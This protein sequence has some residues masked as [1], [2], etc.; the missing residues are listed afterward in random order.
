V[1]LPYIGSLIGVP[2]PGAKEYHSSIAVMSAMVV[3]TAA[4]IAYGLRFR[5]DQV[6][7][8]DPGKCSYVKGSAGESVSNL[9]RFRRAVSISD[10]N[11]SPVRNFHKA[12]INCFATGMTSPY[13]SYASLSSTDTTACRNLSFDAV[14]HE[15]Q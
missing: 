13:N 9:C 15:A 5:F 7:D 3:P 12:L 2:I 1:E 11:K 4:D 10:L 8:G 6:V 14:P